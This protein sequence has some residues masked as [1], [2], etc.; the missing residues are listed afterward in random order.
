MPR[1]PRLRRRRRGQDRAVTAITTS[2]V[3][4]TTDVVRTVVAQRRLLLALAKRDLSDEYV[5]HGLSIVW[6][7]IQPLFTMLV[8]LFTFTMV[9]PT[10]VQ[11]PEG[12]EV[13][14][15]VL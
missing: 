10:R 5:S 7:I 3:D 9:W 2:Y 8:Y 1:P 11:A 14:A 13:D 15:V 4:S 6:N 12:A